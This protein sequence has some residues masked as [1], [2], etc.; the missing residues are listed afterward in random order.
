MAR[1]LAPLHWVVKTGR[2]RPSRIRLPAAL[3]SQRANRLPWM[4][5][6]AK[7]L[8]D[9]DGCYRAPGVVHERLTS[10]ALMHHGRPVHQSLW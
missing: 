8:L 1:L 5:S 9:C 2:G 6:A 3:D 7:W 4:L 10:Q